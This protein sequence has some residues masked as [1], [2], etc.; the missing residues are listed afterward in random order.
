M[1]KSHPIIT[2][3]A[4]AANDRAAHAI[5]ILGASPGPGIDISIKPTNPVSTNYSVE[6]LTPAGKAFITKFWLGTNI[7]EGGRMLARFKGE[8]TDWG[9]TFHTDWGN[10]IDQKVEP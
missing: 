1:T 9:L 10:V 7:L 3:L 4:K 5:A 2:A 8:A 6:G